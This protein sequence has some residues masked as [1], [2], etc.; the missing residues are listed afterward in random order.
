MPLITA[1]VLVYC[2][3]LLLAS[4]RALA[5]VACGILVV[6]W[7]A[8]GSA[9]RAALAAIAIAAVVSATIANSAA[10]SCKARLLA[11]ESWEL[12]LRADAAPGEFVPASHACGLNVRMSIVRGRAPLGAGVMVR[13]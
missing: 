11:Q 9:E 10:R 13:G 2:A 5:A 7:H 1:A 12:T 3:A 4:G 6:V 8:R